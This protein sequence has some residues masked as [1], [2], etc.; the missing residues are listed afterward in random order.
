MC[1]SEG[2]TIIGDNTI[3]PKKGW[4]ITV[5]VHN[6]RPNSGGKSGLLASGFTKDGIALSRAHVTAPHSR[7]NCEIN[8]QL[9]N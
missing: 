6:G 8:R 2:L 7:R 9:N 1:A 4:E 5:A 3:I